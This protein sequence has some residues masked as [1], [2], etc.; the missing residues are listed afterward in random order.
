MLKNVL[1]LY[2]KAA[3]LLADERGDLKTLVAIVGFGV[4]MA[5]I[6]IGA[7]TYAPQTAQSFWQAATDWIRR[8]FG[9]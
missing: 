3:E 6:I 5:L 7:M 1:K 9:F 4:V 2:A 8:G